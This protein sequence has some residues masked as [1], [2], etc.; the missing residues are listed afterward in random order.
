MDIR[1]YAIHRQG[2]AARPFVYRRAVGPHDVL[3]RITHRTMTSGDVQIIDND[4]GDTRYPVVPSHEMV[5]IVEEAGPA[6]A[7]LK[8][9]DRVGVGYQVGACFECSYCRQGVEQFCP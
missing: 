3:V 4:W 2:E 5:G 1:A 6:V 7:D 8:Q 9:G